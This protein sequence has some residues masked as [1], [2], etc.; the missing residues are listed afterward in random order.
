MLQLEGYEVEIIV[1][2]KKAFHC[3]VRF[4][5]LLFQESLSGHREEKILIQLDTEPQQFNYQT[6]KCF[7]NKF[8]VF[9]E[10]GITPRSTLLAQKIFAILN[11]KRNI[12]RDFYDVSFLLG[13][14]T[15][16]D[17][18][19][20]DQKIGIRNTMDLKSRLISHCE[21]IDMKEMAKDVEP[22][23]FEP[24]EINRV[25]QFTQFINQVF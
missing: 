18:E 4:P 11:R 7:L 23:L 25:L 6:E 2:H 24:K 13:L 9:T 15:K 21:N 5:G 12:G 22:F 8:D 1:I 19:Y 14:N 3:K 16:P 17:L 10:I 20:L